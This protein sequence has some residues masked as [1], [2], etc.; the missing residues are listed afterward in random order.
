MAISVISSEL[1]TS[2]GNITIPTNC[3][4]VVALVAGTTNPTINLVAMTQNCVNGVSISTM[5]NPPTGT[6]GCTV[7]QSTRFVYLNGAKSVR[8]SEAGSMPPDF[9]AP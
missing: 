3:D 9:P 6:I 7:G 1:I 4:F 2:T 5:A 8:D